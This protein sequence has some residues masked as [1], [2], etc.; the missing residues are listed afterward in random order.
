MNQS[1]R[2]YADLSFRL[3]WVVGFSLNRLLKYHDAT[4]CWSLTVVRLSPTTHITP[5]KGLHTFR[6]RGPA[7]EAPSETAHDKSR[8]DSVENRPQ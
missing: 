8:S 2:D 4:A 5:A 3:M 1:A 7:D 6:Q